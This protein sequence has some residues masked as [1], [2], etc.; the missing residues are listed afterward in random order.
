M[1]DDEYTLDIT[2]MDGTISTISIDISDHSWISI[3][4]TIDLSNI[5]FDRVMFED[6]MPDPEELK[7][8]CEEYPAL[9]KA[10]E[11]FKTVYKLVHQDWRGKQ[12]QDNATL[13]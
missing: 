5:T 7:Q 3:N 4:D 9:E 12:D 6:R 1:E 8:M 13:F 11:N 10:Y 2:S